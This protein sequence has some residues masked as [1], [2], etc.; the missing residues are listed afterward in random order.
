MNDNKMI[1]KDF[2]ELVVEKNGRVI[3]TSRQIAK[4]FEREHKSVLTS[5]KNF[6]G[7]QVFSRRNFTPTKYVDI[8]GKKRPMY[9]VTKDGEEFLK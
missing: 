7:N 2:N 3:V 6:K 9:E 1:E 5:I 8:Q 4:E